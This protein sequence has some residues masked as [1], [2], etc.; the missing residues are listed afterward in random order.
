MG[1]WVTEINKNIMLAWRG[2]SK[3]K[4]EF[5][6]SRAE[7]DKRRQELL[8]YNKKF[9]TF[10]HS[11]PRKRTITTVDTFPSRHLLSSSTESRL[12]MSRET[13]ST[14]IFTARPK[15]TQTVRC[16]DRS[17]SPLSVIRTH[18]KCFHQ[19]GE[20]SSCVAS[21]QIRKKFLRKGSAVDRTIIRN[22]LMSKLNA[23]QSRTTSS[24]C[25][26]VQNK[27]M[28]DLL[29]REIPL[30]LKDVVGTEEMMR[31]SHIVLGA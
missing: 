22:V 12:K 19:E 9:T 3:H 17:S 13:A 4:H 26:A 18:N 16:H 11:F 7:I 8:D 10:K 24:Y 23:T 31:M 1:K 29:G 28:M 21:P 15:S 27:K 5:P 14:L 6:S 30:G 25:D 2:E 20:Q